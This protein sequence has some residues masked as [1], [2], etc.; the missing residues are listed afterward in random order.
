MPSKVD[1]KHKIIFD[2]FSHLISIQS[3]IFSEN[4]RE[5]IPAYSQRIVKIIHYLY[6]KDGFTYRGHSIQYKMLLVRLH[7]SIDVLNLKAY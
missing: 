4:G 5:L 7:V 6:S 2:I 1:T 3:F